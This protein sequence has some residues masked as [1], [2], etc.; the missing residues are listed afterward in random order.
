VSLNGQRVE[1]ATI[2]LNRGSYLVQVGRRRF[3]RLTLGLPEA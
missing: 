2:V 1:D 3:A